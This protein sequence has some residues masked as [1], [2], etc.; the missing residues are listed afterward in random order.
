[1]TSNT[2]EKVKN[3]EKNL[4]DAADSNKVGRSVTKGTACDPLK[5]KNISSAQMTHAEVVRRHEKAQTRPEALHTRLPAILGFDTREKFT[6]IAATTVNKYPIALGIAITLSITLMFMFVVIN[7]VS[8]N[9]MKLETTRMNS[10][11]E[12]LIEKEAELS[13]ELEKRDD[14]RY[15]REVALNQYGMIDKKQVTKYYIS[16]DKDPK[17]EIID[18]SESDPVVN[19]A[20]D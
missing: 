5:K 12:A 9:K 8:I 4:T 11:L 14:L 17:V 13:I 6:T 2:Y 18:D 20:E 3:R 10:S 15:I 1:M 19:D 7:A 16:M